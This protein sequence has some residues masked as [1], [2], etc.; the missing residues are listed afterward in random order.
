MKEFEIA[1]KVCELMSTN[2]NIDDFISALNQTSPEVK[3][4][5]LKVLPHKEN[6]NEL[7]AGQAQSA[8]V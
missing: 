7:Q 1:L 4:W 3:E 8:D 5:L 2:D 6:S